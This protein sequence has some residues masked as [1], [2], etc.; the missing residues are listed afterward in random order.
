M[1]V[2]ILAFVG[3]VWIFTGLSA[4]GGVFMI[5]AA[6]LDYFFPGGKIVA[7][8]VACAA[9]CLLRELGKDKR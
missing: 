9:I 3:F 7:L 6:V 8:P 1:E 2:A 5:I 4:A